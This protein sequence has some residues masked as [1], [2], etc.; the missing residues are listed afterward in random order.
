MNSARKT[1]KDALCVWSSWPAISL[2][3]TPLRLNSWDSFN[4]AAHAAVSVV[5]PASQAPAFG[6]LKLTAKNPKI[7]RLSRCQCRTPPAVRVRLDAG[8]VGRYRRRSRVAADRRDLLRAL[9]QQTDAAAARRRGDHLL[10]YLQ[11]TRRGGFSS[12]T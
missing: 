8:R 10:R 4:L 12:G 11:V 2:A 3:Q 7:D 1:K 5:P 6:I 9:P